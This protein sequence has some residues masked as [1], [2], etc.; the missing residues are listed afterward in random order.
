VTLRD[1]SITKY[2]QA[3]AQ[4]GMAPTGG[5][6]AALC[7]AQASALVMMVAQSMDPTSNTPSVRTEFGSVASACEAMITELLELMEQDCE[8]VDALIPVLP[9]PKGVYAAGTPESSTLHAVLADATWSQVGVLKVAT[10]L[11][12]LTEGLAPLVPLRIRADL[13]AAVEVTRS[14]LSIALLNV[15]VNASLSNQNRPDELSKAL[16]EARAAVH[17]AGELARHL[18]GI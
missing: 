8:A 14:A 13:A 17:R 18:G 9:S 1:R 10:R 6:V 4:R 7:A 12:G 11:L 2:L 3:L 16:K 15:D 5:A